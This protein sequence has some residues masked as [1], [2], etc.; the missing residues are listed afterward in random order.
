MC[1][2]L[3]KHEFLCSFGYSIA[4]IATYPW[5]KCIETFYEASNHVR[6]PEV[7][8]LSQHIGMYS[9]MPKQGYA[10]LHQSGYKRS[11]YLFQ[12]IIWK[13]YFD[14]VFGLQYKNVAAW[15]ARCEARPATKIGMKVNGSEEE[16]KNYSSPGRSSAIA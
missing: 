12:F 11:Y 1:R 14:T 16:F 7:S 6:L 2:Q 15:M 10:V 3:S 13:H 4:D 5:V 8:S 9:N